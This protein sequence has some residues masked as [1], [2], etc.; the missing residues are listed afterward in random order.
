MSKPTED[1]LLRAHRLSLLGA[2]RATLQ[3]IDAE[4]CRLAEAT[5]A[6]LEQRRALRRELDELE[7]SL[8]E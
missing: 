1:A 7:R 2:L 6:L 5:T 8:K 3:R 4:T